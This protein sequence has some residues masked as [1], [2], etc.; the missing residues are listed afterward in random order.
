[1]LSLRTILPNT[2][3]LLKE[4]QFARVAVLFA[5]SVAFRTLI[6]HFLKKM[7]KKYFFLVKNLVDCKKYSNF[8]AQIF[9]HYLL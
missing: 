4:L 6:Y 7:K 8:A 2:L 5:T 1:M 9:I 3:E